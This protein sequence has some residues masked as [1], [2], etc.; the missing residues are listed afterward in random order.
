MTTLSSSINLWDL[1]TKATSKLDLEVKQ[2]GASITLDV[3]ALKIFPS[4]SLHH[5]D[6]EILDV[7][8]SV[9]VIEGKIT[10]LESDG[11]I[12]TVNDDLQNYKGITD[13]TIINNEATRVAAQN[14]DVS[15][16]AIIA[17]DLSNLTTNFG[18]EQTAR[19]QNDTD[20][21]ALN[22]LTAS[23]TTSISDEQTAR[24]NADTALTLEIADQKTR[25]DGILLGT[26]ISLDSLT[27]VINEFQ[28]SYS[29]ILSQIVSLQ[30]TVSILTQRLDSLTA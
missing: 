25:F 30:N 21:N 26:D 1:E 23:H 3:G 6:G 16:R 17:N 2:T 27:A 13:S 12:A 10:T 4:L 20:I 19:Q 15:Q 28:N 11:T 24:I 29:G 14:F 8:N 7:A 18:V 22:I 9:K 5:A